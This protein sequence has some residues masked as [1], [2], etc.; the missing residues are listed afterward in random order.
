MGWMPWVSLGML[1]A[2]TVLVAYD[3]YHVRLTTRRIKA[4]CHSEAEYQA[5]LSTVTELRSDLARAGR[6]LMKH[7]KGHPQELIDDAMGW[8]ADDNLATLFETPG[9]DGQ[10]PCLDCARGKRQRLNHAEWRCAK[11]AH[12]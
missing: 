8:V 4:M 5:A 9:A 12:H 10:A 3:I 6:S 2:L 1:G 11:H 7:P